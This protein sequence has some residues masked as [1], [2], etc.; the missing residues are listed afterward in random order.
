MYA[1][2]RV[3][4]RM[5]PVTNWCAHCGSRPM[6][7]AENQPMITT[8]TAAK[9]MKTSTMYCGMIRMRRRSTVQRR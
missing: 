3:C 1:P 5:T 4:H 6:T 8:K 7:S 9:T 2:T